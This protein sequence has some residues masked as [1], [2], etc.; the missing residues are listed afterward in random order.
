V[1]S[2][3]VYLRGINHP[4]LYLLF[5]IGHAQITKEEPVAALH[6]AGDRLGYVHLDDN[7]GQRDLHWAL[8]DGVLTR[9]VLRDTLAAL[10]ELHYTGGV[11]LELSSQ[12]PDPHAAIQRSW[13][14]LTEVPKE[15]ER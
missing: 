14:I 11:S 3:L 1:T 10:D 5:D 2:T 8:L 4:N 9:P 15:R 13:Q 6:A 12:L 7:D